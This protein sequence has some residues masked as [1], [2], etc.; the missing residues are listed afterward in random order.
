MFI[1]LYKDKNTITYADATSVYACGG[2]VRF[3]DY[4]EVITC[5]A[6][7]VDKQDLSSHRFQRV[8]C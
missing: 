6:E 5:E 4:L 7:K 2:N 3:Q 8:V 1:L